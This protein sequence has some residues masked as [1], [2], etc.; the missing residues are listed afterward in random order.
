MDWLMSVMRERLVS[1]VYRN[2]VGM[3]LEGCIYR[4]RR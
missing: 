2:K 1:G 3:N 4:V